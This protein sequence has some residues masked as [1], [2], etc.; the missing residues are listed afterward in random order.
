[1]LKIAF[2]KCDVITFTWFSGYCTAKNKDIALKFC[3]HVICMYLEHMYS[4]FLNNLTIWILEV[5]IFEKLKFWILGVKIKKISKIRDSHFVERSIL[6]RLA[7]FDCVLLQNLNIQAVFKHLLFFDPKWRNITSLKRHF[8]KTFWTDVSEVW[9]A[10]LKLM[11][12][13]VLNVLCRY[14]PP[15]FELSRKAGRGAESPPPQLRAC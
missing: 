15:F 8:L 11:L 14:L 6:R 12:G 3:I 9:V 7:F 1:M 5:T 13:K 4:N 10:D 2:Q